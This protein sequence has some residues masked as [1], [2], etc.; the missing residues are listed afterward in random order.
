M[1]HAR[2]VCQYFSGSGWKI[3]RY[4]I[5]PMD[6]ASLFY[7]RQKSSLP[8]KYLHY[9]IRMRCASITKSNIIAHWRILDL[10]LGRGENVIKLYVCTQYNYKLKSTFLL[11]LFTVFSSSITS[12]VSKVNS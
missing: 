6:K 9:F 2:A 11:L 7:C 10:F 1:R 12:S 4:A 5:C 8:Y 3:T